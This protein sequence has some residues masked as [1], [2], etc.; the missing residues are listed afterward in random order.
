MKH[1]LH[2]ISQVSFATIGNA[3]LITIAGVMIV[4]GIGLTTLYLIKYVDTDTPEIKTLQC[5]VGIVHAEC[6][7][8][9]QEMG[10]LKARLKAL[11]QQ[12][13][14]AEGKLANLRAIETAVD[15]VTLFSMHTTP[16]SK[17]S[18]TVG[19]VYS[20]L[21]EPDLS[22][23]YFCYISLDDGAARENRSL[24]FKNKTERIDL[25]SETLRKAD[26]S[27]ETLAFARSVC[28]PLIIGADQ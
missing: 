24:Y 11:A 20:R 28:K 2:S 15:E 3:L 19:T 12:T 5:M 6:P 26:V 25:D 13:A 23:S 14:Q 16:N 18:V 17:Y 10:D 9:A 27:A 22:P 7:R 21:L 8:Y 1:F 4:C